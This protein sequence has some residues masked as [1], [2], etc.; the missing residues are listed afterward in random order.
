[1]KLTRLLLLSLVGATSSRFVALGALKD[2]RGRTGGKGRLG[3]PLF[4]LAGVD[5]EGD[6]TFLLPLPWPGGAGGAREGAEAEECV[7]SRGVTGRDWTR[8][9]QVV[10]THPSVKRPFLLG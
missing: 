4:L 10:G 7:E 1:M 6:C 2:P 3:W 5:Q 8:I 9:N